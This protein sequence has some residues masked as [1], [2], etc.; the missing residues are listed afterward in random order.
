[1]PIASAGAPQASSYSQSQGSGYDPGRDNQHANE[2][3]NIVSAPPVVE[4]TTPTYTETFGSGNGLLDW[5]IGLV[6]T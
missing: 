1:M 2:F 6:I 4:D 5:L 3:A